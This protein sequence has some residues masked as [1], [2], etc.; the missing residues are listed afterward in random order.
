ML[1]LGNFKQITRAASCK[2]KKNQSIISSYL[3]ARTI[4]LQEL[5]VIVAQPEPI[6][7][8]SYTSCHLTTNSWVPY[9]PV[10]P[11]VVVLGVQ[12]FISCLSVTFRWVWRKE[13]KTVCV[14]SYHLPT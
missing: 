11:G 14:S 10:F 6:R 2:K 8:D 5:L 1:F 13:S 3:L 12:F 7:P 4:L 9:G